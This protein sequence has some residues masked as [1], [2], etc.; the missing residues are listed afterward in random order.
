MKFM[1]NIFICLFTLIIQSCEKNKDKG[2]FNIE[3]K[4]INIGS[5]EPIDSVLVILYGGNPLNNPLMPDFNDN[6]PNGNNDTAYSDINGKFYLEIRNESAAFLGWRKEGYKDGEIVWYTDN[7]DTKLNASGNKF[8]TTGSKTILIEYK[9]ECTF[10][11]I[12]KK[13][14][15]NSDNDTLIVSIT[16]YKHPTSFSDPRIY[17][18]KSPFIFNRDRGYCIGDEYFYFKLEYTDIGIWKTKIDSVYVKS[19]ETYSDTIYY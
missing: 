6:P 13:I 4:V 11:S 3:G 18:G 5:N 2:D 1:I 15:V 9:A 16:D 17:Y 14:G 10:N 19:F 12:F 8:F 7:F